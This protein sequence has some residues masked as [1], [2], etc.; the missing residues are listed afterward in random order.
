[1]EY[2]KQVTSI[3]I[4]TGVELTN[5]IYLPEGYEDSVKKFPT[6]LFLHGKGEIGND[7]DILPDG[8]LRAFVEQNALPFILL[9]PQCPPGSEWVFQL[10][11]LKA[12]LEGMVGRYRIDERRIYL[13]G[14]SMGAIGAWHLG[15]K[16]PSTFAAILP[17]SGGAYPFLGFPEAAA[18]L[19]DIPV[20]AFHGK[21]D[22]VLPIRLT[23][24]LVDVLR[25]C[26]GKVK[27]TY[28]ENTGHDAWTRTYGDK[29][30]YD[31][32]LRQERLD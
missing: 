5:F 10:D 8:G 13:T 12:Y 14:L 16:F 19:K 20:W 28:Y 25:K 6:I 7:Y 4:E 17:I 27:Y 30:I 26:G 29:E 9:E 1:M 24:E 11:A 2:I 15:I 3:K 32:L 21:D 18:A 31:W 23:Q 22:D